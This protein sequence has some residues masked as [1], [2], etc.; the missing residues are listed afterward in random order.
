MLRS[1][2]HHAERAYAGKRSQKSALRHI[3]TLPFTRDL[4][5]G[6][7]DYVRL[8]SLPPVGPLRTARRCPGMAGGKLAS[9]PRPMHPEEGT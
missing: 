1:C 9:E 2:R 3:N 4:G 8:V 6:L 7:I 5:N